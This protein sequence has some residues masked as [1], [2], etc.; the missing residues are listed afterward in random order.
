MVWTLEDRTLLSAAVPTVNFAFVTADTDGS[1]YAVDTSGNLHWYKDTQRNGSG[2]VNGVVL[3]S[4]SA[5]NEGNAIATGWNQFTHVIDGGGGVLYTVDANGTLFWYKD[6]AR[7]GTADWAPKSGRALGL[8]SGLSSWNI[9]AQ[10]F[11]GQDGVLYAVNHS[12]YI[13]WFRDLAQNGSTDWD[14][15]SGQ[16]QLDTGG[17]VQGEFDQYIDLVANELPSGNR[18]IY[19]RNYAGQLVFWEDQANNGS[20]NWGPTSGTV[21]AAGG[22]GPER[23]SHIFAGGEAGGGG[24]LY[25]MDDA[26]ETTGLRDASLAFYR[27]HAQNGVLAQNSDGTYYY[28]GWD[29]GSG[30]VIANGWSFPPLEGYSSAISVAPGASLSFYVSTGGSS[31]TV[32]YLRLHADLNAEAYEE[33]FGNYGSPVGGSFTVPGQVRAV[34]A[35]QPWAGARWDQNQSQPADF[36]LNV[37]NSW[38]SGLYAAQVVDDRG[39]ATYISFIIKPASGPTNPI[40]FIVSTNTWDAYNAWGGR[41]QYTDSATTNG[42][43]NGTTLSL[44][45]PDPNATPIRDLNNAGVPSDM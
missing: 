24:I 44:L 38:Q 31:I 43:G 19:G 22:W 25:G 23:F 4:F 28:P 13:Y 39:Y 20:E 40:A 26:W 42:V 5:P 11:S 15:N 41:Y 16:N 6:L 27:D 36:S 8:P 37:P 18:V 17:R 1:I 10:I 3:T 30:N 12:G 35:S 21:I 9:F 34:T 32:T 45:R 7:N 14:P 29:P 2:I 33:P